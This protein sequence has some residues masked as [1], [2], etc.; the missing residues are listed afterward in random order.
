MKF[1]RM[2]VFFSYPP[3]VRRWLVLFICLVAV[4]V[5]GSHGYA[6]Q[7][8]VVD[9]IVAVVN[10]DIITLFDLER[11]LRPFAQN[12]KALRYPPE[13]ARQMLFQVRKDM[14]NQ[15]IDAKLADQE[16]KR[17]QIA[18]SEQ[19][20]NGTIERLKESRSFTDEQLREGL[21]QQG[22]TMEE[23]RKQIKEQILRS[24]LI[25]REVKSKIVITKED[26]NA[27]Y[28]SH[29]EKYA[30]EKKYHLWNIF[31]KLPVDV[32]AAEKISAS[33]QMQ[34]IHDRLVQ[35]ASF[36]TLV[37]ELAESNGPV[38]GADLGLFRL[39]ELSRQ[40][41]AAVK[42]I[43]AGEFSAVLDTDFGYQIIFIQKIQ[44]TPPE[45]IEEV[46]SQISQLL[47][48]EFVDNKYQEWLEALR[49]QAV[50][51]IIQ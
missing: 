7:P 43:K 25:N 20:I 19:E 41:L 9:R 48:N 37:Q 31:I 27:Y 4:L 50:I 15:L 6:Q 38:H 18:V 36:E 12:I 16:I 40:L 28:D 10:N 44:E 49:S 24:K 34:S 2:T 26:I 11:A 1:D 14:L 8:V 22:M 35:G 32:G 47:Y 17:N 23:Y 13:K 45:P 42:Q 5:T 21:S 51:K 3:G 39:R 30:G 33:R 29:Q 46:E